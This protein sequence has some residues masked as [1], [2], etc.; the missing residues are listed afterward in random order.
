MA[1]L[2]IADLDNGKRDLETVDAV[3]NSPLP[4]TTTRYGDTVRTLAGALAALRYAVPVAYASG[5][6]I[7]ERTQT[8]EYH[9][10]IYAPVSVPFTTG[11]WNPGQWYPIQNGLNDH[12]LLV[13]DSLVE[14]E[15]AAA[16]LPDG[17][18]IVVEG[19]SQGHVVAGAYVPDSGTPAVRLQDYT[20]LENYAGKATAVDITNAGIAGRF[21]RRGNSEANGGTV[22]KDAL[23]RSWKRSFSGAVLVT[24]FKRVGDTDDSP[25]FRKA[26]AASTEG[27]SLHVPANTYFFASEVV[28]PVGPCTITGDGPYASRILPIGVVGAIFRSRN[29]QLM[30]S[31][32][33]SDIGIVGSNTA[34]GGIVIERAIH[35]KFSRLLITGTKTVALRVGDGY[36]NTVEDC[37]I[38]SNLGNGVDVSGVNINNVNILRNQIYANTGYGVN[39]GNALQVNIE[40]NGIEANS[41]AGLIVYD[42]KGLGVRGNYFE[43]NSSEGFRFTSPENL[44]VKSDILLLLEGR[45]ITPYS[46]IS[47]ECAVIEN[48]HFTPYGTLGVPTAGLSVDCSVFATSLHNLRVAYNQVYDSSRVKHLVG[49]FNNNTRVKGGSVTIENNTINSFG[50]IGTGLLSYS[51]K[52]THLIKTISDLPLSTPFNWFDGNVLGFT[53]LDGSTGYLS[54]SSAYLSSGVPAINVNPGNKIYGITLPLAAYPELRGKPVW[55]G[56]YYRVQDGAGA[57]LTLSISDGV[58]QSTDSDG[59]VKEAVSIGG[60]W[61]FKSVFKKIDKLSSSLTI[62]FRASPSNTSAVVV[63]SPILTIVG[64]SYQDFPIDRPAVLKAGIVPP[65]PGNWAIGDRVTNVNPVSGQPKGWVY[66]SAGWLSEGNYV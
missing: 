10:A 14:A 60:D 13:F 65:M 54:K 57:S 5:L 41:V 16:T 11:A 2:T 61:A 31:V 28:L 8:V 53:E 38:Y 66:G 35:S 42:T 4:T 59:T 12:K 58:S 3:A 1:T 37:M 24:W 17:S 44:T 7:T 26:L 62:G 18:S 29:T 48:N 25:S 45:V 39:V 49:S 6:A 27:R 43:R 63:A 32:D 15:A 51:L 19:E 52:H 34:E 21:Y 46:G 47:V 30:D 56:M 33:I 22:I 23:G 40:G 64:N 9:G 50:V 20:A 55:F 36:N